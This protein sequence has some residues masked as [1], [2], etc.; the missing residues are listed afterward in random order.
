MCYCNPF[1]LWAITFTS[2]F[3]GILF[4]LFIHSIELKAENRHFSFYVKTQ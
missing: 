3:R 1:F 2:N 4:S